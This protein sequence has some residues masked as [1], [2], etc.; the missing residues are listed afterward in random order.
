M[1]VKYL[2]SYNFFLGISG[3]ISM[4]GPDAVHIING[5]FENNN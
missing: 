1:A 2:I 3:C 4:M 5:V